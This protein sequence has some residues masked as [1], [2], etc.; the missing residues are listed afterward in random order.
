MNSDDPAYFGGYITENF[1]AAQKA[2]DL[3]R[4]QIL[5]L[6]RNSYAAAFIDP[7]R[8]RQLEEELLTAGRPS[9]DT[10]RTST[11]DEGT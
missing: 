1:L 8:R 7:G 2:L 9:V 11:D 5:T 10:F 3:T 6:A 4:E